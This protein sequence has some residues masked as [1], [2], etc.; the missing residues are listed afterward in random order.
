MASKKSS[1]FAIVS[2][3]RRIL[4]PRPPCEPFCNHHCPTI[5]LVFQKRNM[6]WPVVPPLIASYGRGQKYTGACLEICMLQ[7]WQAELSRNIHWENRPAREVVFG[8]QHPQTPAADLPAQSENRNIDC[9]P[10][11]TPAGSLDPPPFPGGCFYSA[12]RCTNQSGHSKQFILEGC[13]PETT[14]IP[15]KKNCIFFARSPENLGTPPPL[16]QHG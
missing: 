9:I 11:D 3:Q 10:S 13:H 1:L 15:R 5:A 2:G 7:T 14:E 16:V 12:V 4:P 6:P 8:I